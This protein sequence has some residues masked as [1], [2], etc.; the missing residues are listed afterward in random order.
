MSP[1]EKLNFINRLNALELLQKKNLE[2][3]DWLKKYLEE[4]PKLVSSWMD[5]SEVNGFYIDSFSKIEVYENRPTNEENKNV[6]ATEAQAKS[7]LAKA[8]LSQLLK[9]FQSGWHNHLDNYVIFPQQNDGVFT[10]YFGISVL[11]Q[12]LAFR[13]REKAVLFYNQHQELIHQ[14]WSEFLD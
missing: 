5:L 13:S 4:N 3:I 1:E 9:S 11:P 12:F 10:A 2:E 8:Q 7:A 6:F 14:Y